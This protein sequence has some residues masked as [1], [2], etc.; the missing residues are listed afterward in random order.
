MKYHGQIIFWRQTTDSDAR[1][2]MFTYTGWYHKY[3]CYC[4]NCRQ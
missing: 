3:Y 1:C 4:I 2:K